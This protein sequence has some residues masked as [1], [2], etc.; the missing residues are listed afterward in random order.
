[1]SINA[2]TIPKSSSGVFHL[3]EVKECGN[4]PASM[5]VCDEASLQDDMAFLTNAKVKNECISQEPKPSLSL[6]RYN[7]F[8]KDLDQIKIKFADCHPV[9]VINRK[10]IV[11]IYCVNNLDDFPVT[12]KWCS[13]RRKEAIEKCSLEVQKLNEKT[14]EENGLVLA[15]VVKAYREEKAGD[16]AAEAWRNMSVLRRILTRSFDK[17]KFVQKF[18]DSGSAKIDMT[19][20]WKYIEEEGIEIPLNARTRPEINQ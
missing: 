8:K 4:I 7:G 2:L 10:N 12:A 18:K 1:M 3:V 6:H 9:L 15:D 13:L 5:I 11:N 17:D 19:E 16:Q 14:K 20:L